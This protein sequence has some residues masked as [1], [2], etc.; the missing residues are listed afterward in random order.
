MKVEILEDLYVK[1]ADPNQ[2]SPWLGKATNKYPRWELLKPF[3]IRV[4]GE[5]HTVPAGFIFN[6]SSVPRF[7]WWLYP[8]SWPHAWR[9]SCVH[10]MGVGFAW[11]KKPQE[12]WDRVL[13]A[14]IILDGGSK[15]DANRFYWAVNF[16]QRGMYKVLK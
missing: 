13:Q 7:L 9:G 14:M 10:D 1:R 16:S 8:P 6:G 12:Y 2:A 11:K 5:V 4:D 15:K 3:V